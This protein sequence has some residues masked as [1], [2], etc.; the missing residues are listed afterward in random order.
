MSMHGT[1]PIIQSSWSRSPVVSH[2]SI[3]QWYMLCYLV[4]F[5]TTGASFATIYL[6]WCSLWKASYV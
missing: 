6:S 5:C 3:K 1:D 4:Y 2:G